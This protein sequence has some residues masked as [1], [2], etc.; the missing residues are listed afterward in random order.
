MASKGDWPFFQAVSVIECMAWKASAPVSDLNVPDIFCLIF[1]FWIP[2]SE[3][4]LSGGIAGS[5]RKLKIL[6]R[7]FRIP[8]F[9]SLNSFLRL[10]RLCVRSLSSLSSQ[11][12]IGMDFVGFSLRSWIASLSNSC[13]YFDQLCSVSRSFRYS[14]FLNK[15]ARHIWLSRKFMAK[16]ALCRSVTATMFFIESPNRSSKTLAPRPLPLK[17]N[18][19][20]T[21]CAIHDQSS[22]PLQ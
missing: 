22:L 19:K 11:P 14:R 16:Y 1:S 17:T 3:A 9:N 12:L 10:S 21:V 6:S 18:V 15:W 2:L 4:L 7:R 13:N 20:Y 5:S 8:L